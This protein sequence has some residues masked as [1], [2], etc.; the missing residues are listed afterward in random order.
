MKS[1]ARNTTIFTDIGELFTLSELQQNLGKR[2]TEQSL[3]R[4]SKAAMIVQEGQIQWIGPQKKLKPLKNAREVSLDHATVLPGFVDCHTHLVFAGHRAHEFELLQQGQ[5]YQQIA[6]A[7]GGI[8]S[9]VKATRKASPKDL[10]EA[11]QDRI[12][13]HLRQGVTTVE[14]KSGYGLEAKSEA[15]MLQVAQ[16]LKGP[17]MVTTYLGLHAVPPEFASS[18]EYVEHVI[19]KDLPRIAKMKCAQRVDAFVEQGYFSAEQASAYFSA[20]R[21]LGFDL[22]VHAEQLSR[23]GVSKLLNRFDIR[24]FDHLVHAND[25]DILEF[26]QAQTTCVLLPTADF[27]LKLPYPKARAM[28]D[29]GCRVALAT[30]Y[31]PGSS[32]SQDI[33]L[34]GL[35]ARMEMKMT[36]PEVIGAFTVGGAYALG[37]ESLVGSLEIGKQADFSVLSGDLS[38]LFYEIGKTPIAQTWVRGKSLWVSR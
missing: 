35:L 28:I 20:A 16:A 34:V 32:P 31:N 27:Y 9:T 19:S 10:T 13:H 22:V 25:S 36:L 23:S 29:G 15:K 14:V 4:L 1:T 3:S 21:K 26:S 24:S 7:G 18:N 12:N 11:A 8:L 37:I 38:D 33:A 6:Q 2:A 17:G 5:T 30:D